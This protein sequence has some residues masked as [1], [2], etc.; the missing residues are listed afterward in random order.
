MSMTVEQL[1]REALALPPEEREEL[2]M[3]LLHDT[4]PD[5]EIEKAWIEECRRRIERQRANPVPLKDAFEFLAELRQKLG[6]Q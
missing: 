1:H 6:L 3:L 5:P 2:A 4:E